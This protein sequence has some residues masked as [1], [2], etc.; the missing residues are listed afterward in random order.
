MV[1]TQQQR[2]FFE[3]FGYLVMPGLV[4]DDIGWITSE[5]EG[6]FSDRGIVHDPNKRT[7]IVPFVDQRE[8]FCT[9]LDHPAI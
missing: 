4:A 5:F 7:V 8:R 2:Q 1:L 3:T 6:V 9:L